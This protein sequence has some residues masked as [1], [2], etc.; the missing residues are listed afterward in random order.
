M[1]RTRRTT[2]RLDGR[3]SAPGGEKEHSGRCSPTLASKS[4]TSHLALAGHAQR[5]A[6]CALAPG[7]SQQPPPRTGTATQPQT[8][9][10]PRAAKLLSGAPKMR[11]DSYPQAMGFVSS[12]RF[13]FGAPAPT[14]DDL[15]SLLATLRHHRNGP[16][17]RLTRNCKRGF[18]PLPVDQCHLRRALQHANRRRPRRMAG[19]ST[20]ASDLRRQ[21]HSRRRSSLTARMR[22]TTHA[23]S[24]RRT[25]MPGPLP[26]KRLGRARCRSGAHPTKQDRE[27]LE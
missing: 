22:R 13:S 2:P 6:F 15:Q 3:P 12:P 4:W 24:R 10:K 25:A 5:S 21:A 19:G 7:K 26:S 9:V 1:G 27:R 14:L 11:S 23:G 17:R 18:G 8:S 16:S 20:L